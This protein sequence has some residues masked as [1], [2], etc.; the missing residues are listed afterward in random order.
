ML[1]GAFEHSDFIADS[2]QEVTSLSAVDCDLSNQFVEAL[3]VQLLANWADAAVSGLHRLKLLLEV[4]PEVGHI[5]GGGRCG[6]DVTD[7]QLV[8]FNHLLG[9]KDRIEVVLIACLGGLLERR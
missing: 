5:S 2:D 6:R 7:P 3:N 9:R 4:L 8:V 1:E